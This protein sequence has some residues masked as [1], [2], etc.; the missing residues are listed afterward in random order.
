MIFTLLLA[1]I[2]GKLFGASAL[3]VLIYKKGLK[4]LTVQG[5]CE[6]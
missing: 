3:G 4:I 6:N 5:V 2:P 1:S